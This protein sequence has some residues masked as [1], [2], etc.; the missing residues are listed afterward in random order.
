MK[1]T[2]QKKELKIGQLKTVEKFAILPVT[3]DEGETVVWLEKY[4]ELYEVQTI[5]KSR[6]T[7]V[8][9]Y[10]IWLAYETYWTND[11]KSLGKKSI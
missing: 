1:F 2:T 3:A 5:L 4:I 6:P 11:W 7:A 10:G 8:G 9:M